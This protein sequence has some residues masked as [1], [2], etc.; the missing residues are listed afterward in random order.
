MS[1]GDC[2]KLLRRD[3]AVRW[4]LGKYRI[5]ADVDKESRTVR[6]FKLSSRGDAYK[7]L[8]NA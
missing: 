3:G 6:V 5:L 4:R 8:R 2:T 7:S 1:V